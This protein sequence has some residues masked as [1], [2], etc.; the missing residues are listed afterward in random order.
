MLSGK[1]G[2][3]DRYI[4]TCEKERK[5]PHIKGENR[6]FSIWTRKGGEKKKRRSLSWESAFRQE[7]QKATPGEEGKKAGRGKERDIM[8]GFSC[9]GRAF[10][11]IRKGG[12]S[13]APTSHQENPPAP[14]IL[15]EEKKTGA[16]PLS[17]GRK[18]VT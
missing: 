12:A 11:P 1:K 9:R 15:G 3:E 16:S 6:Y 10:L 5:S 8:G 18:R 13:L 17:P 14:G 7:Q 2:K 4:A